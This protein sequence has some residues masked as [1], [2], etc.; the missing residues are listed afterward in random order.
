MFFETRFSPN[1]IDFNYIPFKKIGIRL[2][3]SHFL[4]T[5][6]HLNSSYSFPLCEAFNLSLNFYSFISLK[7]KKKIML[8][9]LAGPHVHKKSREQYKIDHN[10]AISYVSVTNFS[11]YKNF[12]EFKTNLYLLHFDQGFHIS[13]F[14]SRRDY[15]RGILK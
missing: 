12:L 13:F 8:T 3:S 9:I 7:K 1:Q 6:E 10:R 11:D 14:Y 2:E 15:V 5:L 4:P